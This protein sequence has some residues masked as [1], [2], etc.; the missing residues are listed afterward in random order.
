[1]IMKKKILITGSDGFVGKHFKQK[2][3][4]NNLTCI[5]IKSGKDAIDFFRQD[6]TKFDLVIHAAATVGGR[7]VIDLEPHRLFNN[8][9]LDSELFQWGLRNRPE[10]VMHF[11]SS[12][13]YP[14]YL[15]E[16]GSKHR[17]AE[18][19]INLSDVRSPDPS[20]YGWS[21]LTGEHL[22]MYARRQGLNVWTFRPFSGYS[23]DQDLDY[24]FPS[25]VARAKRRDNPFE[26]WSDGN[27]VRDWI[28]IDDI[29]D[30]ALT[31]MDNAEPDSYNLCSGRPMSFNEFGT[32]ITKMVGYT[33]EFK[34]ILE[35]PVGVQYRVGDPTK[36][37]NWY[38]PK[39][40]FEAGISRALC[41]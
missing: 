24:P 19:D 6:T 2:L 32:V 31:I 11:S 7:M 36:M 18:S 41:A 35:A 23:H 25:F 5:D 37:L 40:T 28:H 20:I 13:A 17:L 3:A 27:Q 33:P 10:R 1:M 14:M 30:G 29:V 38:T 9:N 26:I 22:A 21:K 34:H 16:K 4:Y 12:A 15:Q 39:I 8:F